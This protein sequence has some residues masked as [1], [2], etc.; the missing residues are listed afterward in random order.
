M[1]MAL[2]IRRLRDEDS[3]SSAGL[4]RHGG[5]AVTRLKRQKVIFRHADT[6]AEIDNSQ[7]YLLEVVVVENIDSGKGRSEGRLAWFRRREQPREARVYLHSTRVFNRQYNFVV[8]FNA[9]DILS[10]LSH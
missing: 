9:L 7:K 2:A 6:L 3:E 10:A 4:A 5:Q 8:R 1:N